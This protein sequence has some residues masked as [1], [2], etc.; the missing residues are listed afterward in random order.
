MDNGLFDLLAVGASKARDASPD[1][2]RRDRNDEDFGDMVAD[3]DN[4]ADDYAASQSADYDRDDGHHDLRGD[5]VPPR[6]TQSDPDD[7]AEA[8]EPASNSASGERPVEKDTTAATDDPEPEPQTA[9]PAG[10]AEQSPDETGETDPALAAAAPAPNATQQH[11]TERL[12]ATPPPVVPAAVRPAQTRGADTGQQTAVNLVNPTNA[13]LHGDGPS[14]LTPQA[15][16]AAGALSSEQPKPTAVES[17][18]QPGLNANFDAHTGAS[19]SAGPNAASQHTKAA[20]EYVGALPPEQSSVA[21]AALAANPLSTVPEAN[22]NG[23][24]TPDAARDQANGSAAAGIVASTAAQSRGA[25][26]RP[27][28]A[29]AAATT[30]QQ[31]GA[32]QA[33]MTAGSASAAQ[34]NAANEQM[35]AANADRQLATMPGRQGDAAP[36]LAVFR[37]TLAT[38]LPD[39][40]GTQATEA[41]K[42]AGRIVAAELTARPQLLH[43]SLTDQ[44]TIRIREAFDA[45]DSQVRIQLQPKELGRI[46]VR[47]EITESGR[48]SALVVAERPDTLELLMRDARGLERALQQAGFDTDSSSLSFDLKENDG[49][50]G[51]QNAGAEGGGS[52]SAASELADADDITLDLAALLNGDPAARGL[53]IRV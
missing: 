2:S 19:R 4:R 53:D 29:T 6:D 39:A 14:G 12:A 28:S 25:L 26:N 30:G 10:T 18:N 9:G 13:A 32:A 49:E 23:A 40:A 50:D 33:G 5:T 35:L 22:A 17:T 37:E 52:E 31:T 16:D 21:D 48:M 27:N 34:Q 8:W 15:T 24:A 51:D 11:V 46:D 41:A 43:M 47:M 36:E 38:V 3:T 42:S 20:S 45:G 7:D 44:V 1:Y